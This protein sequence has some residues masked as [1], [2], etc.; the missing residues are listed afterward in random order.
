M[1]YKIPEF[2]VHWK[3]FKLSNVGA[4]SRKYWSNVIDLAKLGFPFVA[5]LF[6]TVWRKHVH[7]TAP[8]QRSY[9]YSYNCFAV[10]YLVLAFLEENIMILM[11]YRI[12]KPSK[13]D[14]CV[15]FWCHPLVQIAA[16]AQIPPSPSLLTPATQAIRYLTHVYLFLEETMISVWVLSEPPSLSHSGAPAPNENIVQN[17]LNIALLNVFSI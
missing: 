17:H 13:P 9:F 10:F 11:Y 1:Y 5:R 6:W 4:K 8:L 7:I 14:Q 3:L 15:C 16:I 2:R 12:Q